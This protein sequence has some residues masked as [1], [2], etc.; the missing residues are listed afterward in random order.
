ME[1][2]RQR[3]STKI[4]VGFAVAAAICILT[5]WLKSRIHHLERLNPSSSETSVAKAS[6][7]NSPT[8]DED[9]AVY[10]ALLSDSEYIDEKTKEVIIAEQTYSPTLAV[11]DLPELEQE[12]VVSFNQKVSISENHKL[13]CGFNITAKCVLLNKAEQKTAFRKGRIGFFTEHP[14]SKGLITLSNVGFNADQTQALVH[15]SIS[16]GEMCGHECFI[17][18]EKKDGGWTVKLKRL[19]VVT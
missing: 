18:L 12:T 5:L 17:L 7:P 2:N 6:R 4:L 16:W 3:R 11:T 8:P 1:I 15:V 14:R 9:Y 19:N 13:Y 10:S